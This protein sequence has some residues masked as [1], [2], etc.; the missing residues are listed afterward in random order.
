MRL[1]N[2]NTF[3]LEEFLDY[4]APPYAI[5]SHTWGD[6][7]EELSFRDVEDGNINKPGIGSVKFRGCCR[8]AAED[9]LGYA[10]IDTCCIDKTNLVELS[11]AINSMFR[12]YQCASICYA[13]LSDVPSDDNFRQKGSKFQRSR[14]FQRGWTLQELLAPKTMRFY[15]WR[16]LGNK[17]SMSTTI[18]SITGIPR[19]YLLGIAAL[20][21]ASVAQRMSWAAHRDTKRKE[22]LAYCLLGIFNI[23]MPMIY[24]EG[25]EQAFFRLQEQ[26]MKVTRDDSILAWGLGTND[27]ST[28]NT[29]NIIRRDQ[30]L[31]YTS[32]VDMSGG[33]IRAHLPLHTTPMG[34]IIGLLSC[35]PENNSQLV[36]GI[37]LIELSVGSSDEYARPR[38]Y[39]SSLY[40]TTVAATEP[41]PIRI[42]HDNQENVPV[43]L[44]GLFFH[45]EDDDFTDINLKIVDVAPRSCWDEERALIMSTPI[46][47]DGVVGQIL[48]R[49]RHDIQDSKDFVVVLE[50]KKESSDTRVECLVFIC[51][52]NLLFEE[53]VLYLPSMMQKL[54]GKRRA[55][56]E[57]L[58]LSIA[59]ERV[60]RQPIFVIRP[61]LVLDGVFATI[62][63][64]VELGAQ[65]LIRESL[66]LL[67]ENEETERESNELK[68]QMNSCDTSLNEI[69][70]E[71]E[72][73]LAKLK[74]LRMR[75][76]AL[77]AK[78]T[79]YTGTRTKI[80]TRQDEVKKKLSGL[81]TQ[82]ENI[83]ERWD[84]LGQD[85]IL[86]CTLPGTTVLQWAAAKGLIEVVKQRLENGSDINAS[87][88]NGY[89]PLI[90]A[91]LGGQFEVATLL[92]EH[93]AR[94]DAQTQKGA[95]ALVPAAISGCVELVQLLLDK[96]VD[97]EGGGN[98]EGTTL[99]VAA[100]YGHADVVRLL[101]DHGADIEA[102]NRSGV[103][104]L[105]AAFN[106][107]KKDVT[108][109]LID[110]GAQ[111]HTCDE[112]GKTML[113]RASAGGD[114]EIVEQL[115][116]IGKINLNARD[117]EGRT[118]L[119]WATQNGHEAIVQLLGDAEKDEVDAEGLEN[120]DIELVITQTNASYKK[121]VEALKE[122]DGDIVNA[123][124]ALS[125]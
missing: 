34:Q 84:T 104:A 123:I 64:T 122:N 33:S 20:H 102:K 89:T 85:E 60:E 1:I 11:E 67:E 125:I 56:N 100:Y 19:H 37:P 46:A 45:Y 47:H 4:R 95:T 57:L 63:A 92:V 29:G 109:L 3:K 10:W 76:K 30:T 13:F 121:A 107:E 70:K 94:L 79:E 96:G 69:K 118:A 24:G 101:L 75:Q 39:N 32:S 5:L 27:S 43:D 66:Q 111:V 23:T 8:Q 21:T 53:L 108:K 38:G 80:T 12:W 105:V 117:K 91:S 14:W 82:W 72:T 62:D 22:D 35:G 25:G 58:S 28:N 83:Q 124:M 44:G 113:I 81:S 41:K 17:G 40:L 98:P 54:Y 51:S 16:L 115:L 52:R 103:T 26:I 36:V 73:I 9:G 106:G 110:R 65:K 74:E 114:T 71:Q 93:G 15:E 59:L 119:E 18:A 49:L 55:K 2:V 68:D 116:A 99:Q 88:Q 7:Y 61:E 112:D 31:K 90:V 6:D 77:V 50:Y 87:D 42:K 78:E 120:K 48:I 97:V 86:R